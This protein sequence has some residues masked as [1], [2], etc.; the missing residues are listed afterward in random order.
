MPYQFIAAYSILKFGVSQV[1]KSL[2][3]ALLRNSTVLETSLFTMFWASKLRYFQCLEPP[4][5][6]KPRYLQ[7]FGIPKCSKPRYL[8]GVELRGVRNHY[9]LYGFDICNFSSFQVTRNRGFAWSLVAPSCPKPQNLYGFGFLRCPKLCYLQDSEFQRYP[10]F[11][12]LQAFGP[13]KCP[14]L[15]YL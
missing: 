1:C 10:K 4:S 6:S 9:V 14:K 3:F 13:P 7:A 2:I 8:Q 5:C 15:W 12:Y 11:G